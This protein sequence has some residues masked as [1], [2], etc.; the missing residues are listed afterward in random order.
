[1]AGK[2]KWTRVAQASRIARYGAEPLTPE[3][4]TILRGKPRLDPK[5]ARPP[6]NSPP[7][8]P[9]LWEPPEGASPAMAAQ[10]AARLAAAD[11]ARQKKEQ[12]EARRAAAADARL[13]GVAVEQRPLAKWKA[14]GK[15]EPSA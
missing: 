7:R 6:K 13:R 2:L 12:A 11:R 8:K 14:Q 10:I 5:T 4:R 9:K 15:T 1:M 3:D